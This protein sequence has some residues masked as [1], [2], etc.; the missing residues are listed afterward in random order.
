MMVNM[1]VLFVLGEGGSPQAQDGRFI[2]HS[3]GELTDA[4]YR[5]QLAH[6]SRMFS[7]G[8]ALAYTFFVFWYSVPRGAVR[9]RLGRSDRAG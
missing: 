1:G 6:V 7:A 5:W 4:E 9:S 3:H 8:W 2:L